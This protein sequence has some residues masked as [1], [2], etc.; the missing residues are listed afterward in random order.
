[1]GRKG[2]VV[3]RKISLLPYI[4]EDIYGLD[5]KS[6]Q[7]YGWEIQKFEIQKY[8]KYSM[9]EGVKVAVIDTGCDLE[10]DDLIDNLLPGYNFVN[11]GKSPIDR[12]CHG[13]H[14]AG[15]VAASDNNLGMVGV[16][17]RAKIIPVKSLDD[18]GSGDLKS[19]ARGIVWAADN[20]A[21][22]ITMSLG[23]PRSSIVM[24]KAINHAASKGCIIFCAAGNSGPTTDIMYPARY[25]NTISIAA[26]DINLNRTSFS[27]SGP[28][29]DFLAPGKDIL[30]CVPGNKYAKLSG[31]SMSNPFAVGC[32]ALALSSV[33]KKLSREQLIEAF[34]KTAQSLEE[35]KYSGKKNYEGYGIIHPITPNHLLNI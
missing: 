8:W 2:E 32:A 6:G 19:V 3:S 13:T 29:L 14:V 17:P 22:I 4:R 34:K 10:H 7:F 11:E 16:A 9:G 28:S 31:T 20:G 1:M 18:N 30:S 23:S 25:K 15:T 33:G 12:N 21:D 35:A 24:E 27:C 26:I 5:T